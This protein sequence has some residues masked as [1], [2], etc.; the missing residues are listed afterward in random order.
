MWNES[1]C[2]WFTTNRRTKIKPEYI[3]VHGSSRTYVPVGPTSSICE[4][5]IDFLKTMISNVKKHR[6]N[7]IEYYDILNHYFIPTMKKI[8][9]IRFSLST[10]TPTC[11]HVFFLRIKPFLFLSNQ[12]CSNTTNIM[13]FR[14]PSSDTTNASFIFGG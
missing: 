5:M 3:L 8:K 6:M 7:F 11:M 9:P 12:Q 13:I 1:I 2:S 10:A 14:F 4:E